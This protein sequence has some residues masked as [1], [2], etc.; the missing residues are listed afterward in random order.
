MKRWISALIVLLL[1]GCAAYQSTTQ[2]G[3]VGIERRQLLLVPSET[4][5]RG[6]GEAYAKIIAEAKAKKILNRDPEEVARLRA[7]ADRLI[8]QTGVFRPDAPGW[9]WEINLI[10]AKELNAWCMPG[11]KIVFYTGI[12]ETLQ[13][14]DDEV[15]AIMGHE[16]AH[17]LREHARERSSQTA[18]AQGAIGI[19][20]QLLGFDPQSLDLASWVTNVA[21]LLPNSREHESEADRMGVELAARAGYDPYGAVRVWERMQQTVS[22]QPPEI[23]STHPSN[24]NRIKELKVYAKR[25]EPLYKTSK[26][27]GRLQ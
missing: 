2:T 13:L 21:I 27:A 7:V 11:G 26:K 14:D 15:A 19:G 24:E 16:I 6:A 17:A 22:G 9:A 5:R 25:V 1:T 4:M 8:P 20:G 10:D 3:A 23:L 18:I 12:I